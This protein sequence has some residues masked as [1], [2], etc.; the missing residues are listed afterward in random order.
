[1]KRKK[2]CFKKCEDSRE[3]ERESEQ[4]GVPVRFLLQHYVGDYAGDWPC[5]VWA[6]WSAFTAPGCVQGR[7]RFCENFVG[8]AEILSYYRVLITRSLQ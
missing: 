8:C 7:C 2:R 1:M 6:V 4:P 3:R 5:C